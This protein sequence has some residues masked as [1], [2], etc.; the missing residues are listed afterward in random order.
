MVKKN[1]ANAL[2][3]RPGKTL[4]HSL[5]AGGYGPSIGR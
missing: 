5:Q 1:S 3:G 2:E 4:N